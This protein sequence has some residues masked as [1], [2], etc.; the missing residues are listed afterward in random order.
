MGRSNELAAYGRPALSTIDE[1]VASDN[2]FVVS[3]VNPTDDASAGERDSDID[4]LRHQ[5]DM[6]LRCVKA[7]Q[8]D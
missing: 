2:V 4:R 6:L 7:F 3:D 8:S 5:R 1:S